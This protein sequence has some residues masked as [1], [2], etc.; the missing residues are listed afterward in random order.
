MICV[1][2][3]LIYVL[4]KHTR[5]KGFLHLAAEAGFGTAEQTAESLIVKSSWQ[6]EKILPTC[7]TGVESVCATLPEIDE[8]ASNRVAVRTD[9][10]DTKLNWET[11]SALCH[12]GSKDAGW[13]IEWAFMALSSVRNTG[14]YLQTRAS[15][16]DPQP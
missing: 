15:T 12:I 9:H 5:R 7:E 11:G 2:H 10:T 13:Q 8:S 1:W 6:G 16:F 3:G 14:A 4:L